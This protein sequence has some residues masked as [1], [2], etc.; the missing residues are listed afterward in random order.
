MYLVF[1]DIGRKIKAVDAKQRCNFLGSISEGKTLQVLQS[2]VTHL[3]V[4]AFSFFPRNRL[5]KSRSGIQDN[6][7]VQKQIICSG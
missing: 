4:G 5:N 6:L 1:G 3:K 7:K 2:K